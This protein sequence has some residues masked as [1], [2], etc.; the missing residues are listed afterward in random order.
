MVGDEILAWAIRCKRSLS[1]FLPAARRS[2]LF[3]RL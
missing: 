3:S 2:R 1:N